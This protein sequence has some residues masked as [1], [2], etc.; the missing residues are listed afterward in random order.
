M[1]GKALVIYKTSSYTRIHSHYRLCRWNRA[2]HSRLIVCLNAIPIKLP[3]VKTSVP[4]TNSTLWNPIGAIVEGNN[5]SHDVQLYFAISNDA[6]LKC[7]W[8]YWMSAIFLKCWFQHIAGI[9]QQEIGGYYP[10]SDYQG[11]I[12][13]EWIQVLSTL[14]GWIDHPLLKPPQSQGKCIANLQI[15]CKAIVPMT[16][17]KFRLE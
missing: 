13:V 7:Y 17:G 1:P 15:L 16:K 14:Q 9:C 10:H 11:N 6:G 4:R 2:E 12:C 8:R 3:L 5:W